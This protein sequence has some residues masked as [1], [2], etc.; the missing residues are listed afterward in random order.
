[1]EKTELWLRL[2][3]VRGIGSKRL[4]NRAEQLLAAGSIGDKQ[5]AVSG[6]DEMQRKQFWQL[7]SR[8]T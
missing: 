4:I 6:F 2:S 3:A 7:S 8:E 1:M 5:L